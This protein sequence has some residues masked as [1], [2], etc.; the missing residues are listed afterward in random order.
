MRSKILLICLCIPLLL[1]GTT[2]ALA[3]HDE[4]MGAFTDQ[5]SRVPF[6]PAADTI[7]TDVEMFDLEGDGDL[8]LFVTRGDL[9]GG[10]RTNLLFTNNGTGVFTAV[11]FGKAATAADFS[12]VELGDVNGDGRRD[13]FLSVSLG[14]E[15]LMIL[16]VG[17]GGRVT[18]QDR[19]AAQLPAGQPADVSIET[20]LF[21]A[22]GDGDLDAIVA[23]EDPFVVPGTQ[24]RLYLNNGA[25]TFTDATGNLPAILDD[26]S[27][28]AIADFDEDGDRDVITVN[29]GPFFYLQNDGTGRFT[30]QSATHLPVQPA[31]RDSGRDAVVAD[32]DSDGDL[33]VIFAIS[34]SDQG[35]LLWLNNGAGVFTDVS[36]TH[37]PLAVLASQDVE[38]CDLEGDGDLD[39]I[40]ANTGAVI[41]PPTDHRFVG[42]Q[43]RILVNDGTGHFTD[44]TALHLP[45]VIDSS[46]SVACG[47]ITGDGRADLVVVNGKSEPIRVY[48]QG[49]P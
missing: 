6:T 10:P 46:F 33:D 23:N 28:F 15:R 49:A 42:A 38:G 1:V 16:N 29:N 7:A 12:D 2:T 8:D 9:A 11:T 19:T 32:L 47:D 44:Q 31:N 4:S 3:T 17:K 39:I 14:I 25:G 41:P 45:P 21:D 24:N 22:D 35:P 43:D 40:E 27:A 34:R 13:A 20:G 48:I 30:N 26:S 18:F 5:S 37:V 36:A